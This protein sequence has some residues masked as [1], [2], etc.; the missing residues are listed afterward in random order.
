MNLPRI[1]CDVCNKPVDNT[2]IFFKR[3]ENTFYINAYCHGQKDTSLM[4]MQMVMEQWT[5]VDARAFKREPVEEP[6]IDTTVETV[7]E[8]LEKEADERSGLETP[9]P[10]CMTYEGPTESSVGWTVD[11]WAPLMREAL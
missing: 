8:Q 7:I 10:L 1:I 6:I 4:P 11:E 5:I 2:E 9:V 3:E